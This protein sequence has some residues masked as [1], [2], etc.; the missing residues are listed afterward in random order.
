MKHS[1]EKKLNIVFQVL[2][3]RPIRRLSLDLHIQE[4]MIL[5]WVRKYN[6]S[7]ESGLH[8]QPNIRA[9]PEMKEEIVRLVI[10]NSL[11]LPQLIL[12]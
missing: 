8:K 12:R 10:E 5:E 2:K 6:L 7:G 3:G 4:R 1:Y 9:T 11:P